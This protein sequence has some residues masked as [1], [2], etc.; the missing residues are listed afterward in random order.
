[1]LQRGVWRRFLS[2]AEVVGS[3]VLAV[4]AVGFVQ[5]VTPLRFQIGQ[6]T[7]RLQEDVLDRLMLHLLPFGLVLLYVWLLGRRI[8]P[9]WIV[10]GTVLLGLGTHLI[11]LL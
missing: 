4:L 2:G 3:I 6:V 9:A 8:P 5:V 11:G 10:V 1:L 7:L